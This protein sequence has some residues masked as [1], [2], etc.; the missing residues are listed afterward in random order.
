MTVLQQL[1]SKRTQDIFLSY[2]LDR[3][4][5]IGSHAR[6]TANSGS[7]I[8]LIFAPGAGER[9]SLFRI[10]GLKSHLEATLWTA[11]DLV[12][13]WHIRPELLPYIE[14]DKTLIYSHES[15]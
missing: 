3:V 6:G 11:V 4:Y 15:R 8:D 13:E 5:L 9:F 1:T 2:W 14:Q 12:K 7:D 10:G